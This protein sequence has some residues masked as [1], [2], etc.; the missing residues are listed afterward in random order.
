VRLAQRLQMR[1][2]GARAVHHAP[3]IDVEQPV[4]LRLVDLLERAHQRHAGIVDDDA[5]RGMRDGRLTRELRDVVGLA[6]VDA[7]QADLACG[8][9][10]GRERLQPGLVAIGEREIAA[11]PRKLDRQR[12]ADAACR[13][14]D[15]GGAADCSHDDPPSSALQR[16]YDL[17]FF[18]LEPNR[19]AV[20]TLTYVT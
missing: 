12:A 5:E 13:S 2:E 15:G 16:N 17:H 9:D 19:M 18:I 1:Q 20:P 3:E 11:P 7:M 4:H 6:D 10:L 8:S 14:G